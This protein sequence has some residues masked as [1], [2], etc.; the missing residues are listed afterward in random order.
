MSYGIH[1][2][3]YVLVRENAH[4][5][6]GTRKIYVLSLTET[7]KQNSTNDEAPFLEMS[8]PVL[9]FQEVKQPTYFV[10]FSLHY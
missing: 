9:S 4:N 5:S 1:G 2:I 6:S 10:Y 8:N 3:I 7:I